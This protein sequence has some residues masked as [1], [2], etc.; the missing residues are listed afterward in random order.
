MSTWSPLGSN[1]RNQQNVTAHDDNRKPPGA[2][3][4]TKDR[5][6]HGQ[7]DEALDTTSDLEDGTRAKR[8]C[9]MDS[10]QR[11][12]SS[13]VDEGDTLARRNSHEI[14]VEN[15][16]E[17]PVTWSSL[18]KKG[19]LMVLTIARLSEP[20]TNV[21]LAAYMY[22]QLRFFD[23]DA[24]DKVISGQGGMLTA[25]FAAAQFLTAIWW[26]RAADTSW[27]GRKRVLLIGLC[28]T[29]VSC[30]GI[31]FSTSFAQ[32]LFFRACAGCLNGNVGVMRT[33]ISEIIK[34]KKYQ[35][36]AFLLL[37]MCFNIGVVIG[38]IL[39]GFLADPINSFPTVFGPG[40]SIGGKEGVRWMTAFPYALPSVVNAIFISTSAIFVVFGLDETHAAMQH[41]P[42][43]GRRL[44]KWIWQR[45][46]N[47]KKN[48]SYDYIPIVDQT[49]LRDSSSFAV[50]DE[51]SHAQDETSTTPNSNQEIREP[52]FSVPLREIFTRNVVLTLVQHHLLAM[53][54]SAFNALIFLFLPA[55]RSDNKDAHLPFLFTGGLGLSSEKVGLATAII[56]VI[57]FPLQILIYPR[58]NARLGTL[59]S[60]RIFLP[61]SM[62]AYLLIPFLALL[63]NRG[64]VTWPALTVVLAL[65][66]VSRTFALPGTTLLVNNC[67]PHP[68]VLGTIHGFA[69]SV[70]S[71]ARTIGPTVGGWVLGLGLLGNCVGAVW[72]ALAVVAVM[73]WCL[74]W[75]IHEGDAGHSAVARP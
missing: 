20:L 44:G 75:V 46:F 50:L 45:L 47:R 4:T 25:S 42:D 35:S 2:S 32:A 52:K 10:A 37:P 8:P 69:Q 15:K 23:P 70:S 26:G 51:T 21:S 5:A 72:W 57:G 65:Q 61:F 58:M 74:L 30:I 1:S 18:P 39:G 16:Q 41:K 19:Q 27:I 68:N 11:R 13:F 62:L 38:P 9:S 63:P 24:S 55:A 64:Y 6:T 59:P 28:G 22:Y 60:Y 71:G 36:R 33:M 54:V 34:E 73:N 17:A 14:L 56:G 43:M 66:V 31:G 12:S 49:E 29:A 7:S 48:A 67:T 40:S 53:H 3:P